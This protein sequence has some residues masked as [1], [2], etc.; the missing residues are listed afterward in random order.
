LQ[1]VIPT[2]SLNLQVEFAGRLRNDFVPILLKN[3]RISSA[4]GFDG[5]PYAFTWIVD[6]PLFT[7]KAEE[8]ASNETKF[9]STHHPFTAPI[10]EHEQLVYTDPSRVIGQHFDLVMN[11]R[12]VAGGSQRIHDVDT[13]KYVLERVLGIS[14]DSMKHFLDALAMGCPPHGG[15]AFGLDR[16]ISL[17][18]HCDSIRDVI[19]FP[20]AMNGKDLLSGAPA[21]IDEHSKKLYNLK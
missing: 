17:M 8:N 20:K 5:N 13:Q 6:F 10:Q 1:I 16:L 19:A 3:E 9:D 14:I 4:N 12:E 18:L 11:G 7:V 2:L 15:I 21:A